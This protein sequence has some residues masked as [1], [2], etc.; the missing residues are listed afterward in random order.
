MSRTARRAGRAGVLRNR[1]LHRQRHFSTIIQWHVADRLRGRVFNADLNWQ[2]MHLASLLP[3]GLLADFAGIRAGYYIGG[4]LQVAAALAGLTLAVP[5]KLGTETSG[6]DHRN[7]A[8]A[9]AEE[10]WR[11]GCEMLSRAMSAPM[12]GCGVTQ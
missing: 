4:V 1:H 9:L 5:G 2:S 10:E 11:C 6:G 12:C 8:E 3:G 7:G